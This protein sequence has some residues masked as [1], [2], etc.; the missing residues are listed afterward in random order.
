MNKPKVLI[1]ID[2][3]TPGYKA[4]GPVQSVANLIDN[5]KNHFS[6]SVIT[7]N[8]DYCETQAYTQIESNKW[9]VLENETRVFYFSQAQLNYQNIKQLIKDETP[10]VVY[11]NGIYSFYFTL[12]PLFLLRKQNKIKT[13]IAARG[14]LSSGSL[15]VKGKK[16]KTFLLLCRWLHLFNRVCFHATNIN[17][18][19][20]IEKVFGQ[21]TPIKIAANLPQK[22]ETNTAT[23]KTKKETSLRLVNIARISPEKNLLYALQVLTQVKQTVTFDFYGPVYNQEYW[24]ACQEQVKKL[25]KN[26]TVNYGG[27]LEPKNVLS[28]LSQYDFLFMPSTGENFGHIILQAFGAA[29]PVIISNTTPW[30]NLK[31]KNI[32]IELPLNNIKQMAQII[33][34]YTLLEPSTYTKMSKAAFDFASHFANNTASIEENKALFA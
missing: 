2:W 5:L 34:E 15:S 6:F 11:L 31:D 26:I 33:D 22:F 3:Y 25:P 29:V 7:R 19:Q 1:F 9:N 32:G 10:D 8:T 21:S 27:S 18:K 13:V 14:M 17:E 23:D 28:T 12:I 24:Q 30:K 16:K 4:G 20:D